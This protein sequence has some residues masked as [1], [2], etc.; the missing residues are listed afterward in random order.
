MKLKQRSTKM[1]EQCIDT[2]IND[3]FNRLQKEHEGLIKY[4]GL[5]F[6]K[7]G[8]AQFRG[9]TLEDYRQ[10]ALMEAWKICNKYSLKENDGKTEPRKYSEIKKIFKGTLWTKNKY[11]YRKMHFR[12]NKAS[13]V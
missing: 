5:I 3:N 2:L 6:T 8:G 1:S 7:N 4:A 11:Y 9:Q 13:F 12:K 10:D